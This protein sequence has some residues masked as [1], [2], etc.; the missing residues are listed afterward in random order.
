MERGEGCGGPHKFGRD[1]NNYL[2]MNLISE[3]LAK[4]CAAPQC[5]AVVRPQ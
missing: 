2:S 5:L 1:G 3:G 4:A